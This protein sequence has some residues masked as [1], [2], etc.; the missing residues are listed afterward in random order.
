MQSPPPITPQPAAQRRWWVAWS[1]RHQRATTVALTHAG[2]GPESVARER[3]DGVP[4]LK[5]QRLR[6]RAAPLREE[7]GAARDEARPH[8]R[9][10]RRA[11][12]APR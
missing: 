5:A 8:R 1:G 2:R 12:G 3:L 10:D 11:G 6:G 4:R 7:S 9:L